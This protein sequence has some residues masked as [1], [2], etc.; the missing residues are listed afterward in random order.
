MNLNFWRFELL[1]Y[2]VVVTPSET[3]HN[4]DSDS[5]GDDID[6]TT[7]KQLVSSLRYLCNIRHAIYRAVGMVSKFMSKPKWS[8]YH[9][10]VRILRYIKGTLKYEDLKIKVNKSLKLMIDNKSTINRAK[11]SVLHERIKHIET[12]FPFLRSQVQNGVLEVM[13]CS[14]QKQLVD[15]LT[16]AIKTDQFLHLRDEI[17]VISFE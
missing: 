8:H 1:N 13:Y 4:L 14:T 10:A 16:K 15:V 3:N 5:E 6:V 12:K 2:K 17:S 9:A 11:N 7:F